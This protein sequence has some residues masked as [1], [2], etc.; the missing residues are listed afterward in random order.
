[1]RIVIHVKED[2][3]NDL[4]LLAAE[5]RTTIE[6]L[7]SAAV[8]DATLKAM[9]GRKRVKDMNSREDLRDM[10]KGVPPE[11]LAKAGIV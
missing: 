2:I 3:G 8:E 10:L 4:A 5:R 9:S 6:D 7:A 1:M 11:E